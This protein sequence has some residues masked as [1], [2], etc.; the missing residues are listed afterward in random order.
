MRSLHGPLTVLA[1]G[2]AAATGRAAEIAP[3]AE[4]IQPILIGSEIP[5]VT[6]ATVE[7]EPIALRDVLGGSPTVLI[8][9]R[10]GW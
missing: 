6:V 1:L 10:G 4:E 3:S 5:D 2:L 7:G 9:Y 8:V